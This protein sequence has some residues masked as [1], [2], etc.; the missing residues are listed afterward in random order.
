MKRPV[1]PADAKTP[2]KRAVPLEKVREAGGRKLIP[3]PRSKV[4]STRA[5]R[6]VRSDR[7][8]GAVGIFLVFVAALLLFTWPQ[9][10]VK[11][12]PAF[13][14]EWPETSHE[15]YNESALHLTRDGATRTATQE[16]Q[17]DDANI[18]RITL[19]TRWRD[20]VGDQDF[21]ADNVSFELRGPTELNVTLKV[22]N[23]AGKDAFVT[24]SRNATVGKRPDVREALGRT[25]AEAWANLGDHTTRNGT[26]KWTLT[27]TLLYA[28]DDYKDDFTRD[29]GQPCPRQPPQGTALCIPD[30]G[31][32]VEV[33]VTYLTYA[34]RLGKPSSA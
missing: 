7:I 3:V 10:V 5:F 19:H 18:T 2:P 25:E 33:R 8:A 11:K 27:V 6:R 22:I 34:A 32:D 20:D 15:V 9:P 29:S 13:D 1:S 28:G 23:S 17:I 24:Q 30:D 12:P 14:V 4:A 31:N 21:E 26:G 16:I